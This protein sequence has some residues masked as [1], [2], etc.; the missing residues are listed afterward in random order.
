MRA[1]PELAAIPV[2]LLGQGEQ[3]ATAVELGVEDV[4]D[5]RVDQ[6]VFLARLRPLLRLSTVL[7]E[8]ELRCRTATEF[9]VPSND[10]AAAEP[11]RPPQVLITS[12][13]PDRANA[14][15]A[16]IGDEATVEAEPDAYIA[17]DKLSAGSFQALILVI[18]GEESGNRA[19]H[20]C[21]YVRRHPAL[22]E[23]PMLL[24]TERFR[25]FNLADAYRTGAN[26]VQAWPVDPTS[27]TMG[28]RLLVQRRRRLIE[29]RRRLAGTLVPATED[30]LRAV[31]SRAFLDA[32]LETM[33]DRPASAI[34]FS[35][36]N[37]ADIRGRNGE[38]AANSLL[39]QVA[40]W[41]S[42]LV[43]VEDLAARLEE[44]QFCVLLRDTDETQAKVVAERIMAVLGTTPMLLDPEDGPPV[45]PWLRYGQATQRQNDPPG[46]L[47][48]RAITEMN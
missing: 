37:L 46:R 7:S 28:L 23:L 27:F 9:G 36:D 15:T 35:V 22:Y 47:I 18:D 39:R 26:M 41:I 10:P 19:L 12:A 42:G 3:L 6:E 32:H 45:V 29:A 1:N 20:L 16:L 43:R 33:G 14:I 25:F 44:H 40:D 24:I 13:N 5:A 21:S 8:A 48:A 11:S 17:G 2:I 38:P 31:Y 30:S 4:M 34:A